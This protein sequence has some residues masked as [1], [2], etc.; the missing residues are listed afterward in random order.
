MQFSNG[1]KGKFANRIDTDLAQ[2][3]R[4][5]SYCGSKLHGHGQILAFGPCDS[6]VN[7]G[8]APVSNEH[9]AFRTMPQLTRFH[10]KIGN[11]V[12]VCDPSCTAQCTRCTIN[13]ETIF[14]IASGRNG[15]RNCNT[16]FMS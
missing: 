13:R 3:D 4:F 5:H 12:V 2:A 6:V 14:E 15:H 10:G 8:E 1:C 16:H 11:V 7:D 9:V